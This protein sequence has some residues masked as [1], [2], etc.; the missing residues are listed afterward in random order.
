MKTR[1]YL[2]Q[3]ALAAVLFLVVPLAVLFAQDTTAAPMAE[4]SIL[5]SLLRNATPFIVSVFVPFII[6]TVKKFIPKLMAMIP[7]GW[8]WIAAIVLGGLGNMLGEATGAWS[9]SSSIWVQL[10]AGIILGAVG[11]GIREG[12]KHL[13]PTEKAKKDLAAA[14]AKGGS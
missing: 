2:S 13:T 12:M 10:F 9:L 6:G 8:V 14:A 7:S 4:Q 1:I 11:V 3:I 5:E